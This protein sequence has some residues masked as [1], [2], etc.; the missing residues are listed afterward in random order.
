MTQKS[1]CTGLTRSQRLECVAG[2]SDESDQLRG[3][4]SLLRARLK[5]GLDNIG[6]GVREVFQ[7]VCELDARL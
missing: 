2:L 7:C 3:R 4:R 6:G 5:Q 1:R